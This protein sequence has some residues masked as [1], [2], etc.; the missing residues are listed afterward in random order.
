MDLQTFF[1]TAVLLILQAFFLILIEIFSRKSIAFQPFA[2]PIIHALSGIIALLL[3]VVLPFA[4]FILLCALYILVIT[5]SY[6]FKI[7]KAIHM[8]N[9]QTYGELFFPVGILLTYLVSST[10]T[11]FAAAILILS[12]S[13][14]LASI[15]GKIR[16]NTH[17]SITGSF[18][19]ALSA[20]FIL[21]LIFKSQYIFI[22]PIVALLVSGVEYISQKGIDDILIP[23]SVCVLL[24]FITSTY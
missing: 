6:R 14:P 2:R 22:L 24:F 13:D 23:L 18:V 9:R 5:F 1:I 11:H 3:A 16:K 21:I 4:Y 19:F 7:F 12:L 15:A 17:K 8:T 20:Y 10:L